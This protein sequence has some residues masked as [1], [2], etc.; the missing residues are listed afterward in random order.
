MG[1]VASDS[2]IK[3]LDDVHPAAKP[4]SKLAELTVTQEN[5]RLRQWHIAKNIVKSLSS[6]TYN[7]C[8]QL[9]LYTIFNRRPRDD[10]HFICLCSNKMQRQHVKG[11]KGT[12]Q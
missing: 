2:K 6:Q 5:T 7:R 9:I 11:N 1:D 10:A 3:K 4:Y 12:A 8:Q